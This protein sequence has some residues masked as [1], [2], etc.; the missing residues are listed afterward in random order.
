MTAEQAQALIATI[1]ASPE[2]YM[3]ACKQ[4]S[5]DDAET[6]ANDTLD[7]LAQDAGEEV[8]DT[9]EEDNAA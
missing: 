4:V 7:A 9:E 1:K 8:A 3:E 5:P 6:L 2:A